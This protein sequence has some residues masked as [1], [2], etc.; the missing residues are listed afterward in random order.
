MKYI[1]FKIKNYKGIRDEKLK[2]DTLPEMKIFTLVGLNESG[3]TSV[4]EA[5]NSFQ[6]GIKN[7]DGII[8]K[9]KKMNFNDT[10]EL[11]A[12]AALD[13]SDEKLIKRFCEEKGFLLQE[14]ISKVTITRKLKY[15]DSKPEGK[16]LVN[17]SWIINLNGHKTTSRKKAVERLYDINK[18]LWEEVTTYVE[19]SIFPRIILYSNFLFEIP[20]KIY[21][22]KKNKDEATTPKH[23]L[24]TDDQYFLL[25]QDILDSLGQDLRVEDHLLNRYLSGESE[26]LD[27]INHV[28]SA[29]SAKVSEEVFQTWGRVSGIDINGR[30]VTF[31]D[32]VKEDAD[33]Y[34]L[35]LK[36]KEGAK[37]YLVQERSL[38]FRWF[39]AFL[40]FTQFRKFR[41][42]DPENTLFL[43]DEPASNLHQTGQQELLTLLDSLTDKSTVIYSTHSHHLISPKWLAG[44]YIVKNEAINPDEKAITD[45]MS[46]RATDIKVDRYFNF[47]AQ[48]PNQSTHFQPI[49]DV[50]EYRPSGLEQI[51]SIAI[52]EGK[53]DYYNF[54]Y[55][56][57][58]N[59]VGLN[60]YPANG[61]GS[62]D[63]IIALYLSWGR[64]FIV[65]LDADSAGH[66]EKNRYLKQFG[67][68][69]DNKIFCLDDVS[70]DFKD[71]TTESL[72]TTE[73]REGVVR[74]IYGSTATYDKT[75]YNSAL[76]K[77]YIDGETFKFSKI[78]LGNFK[79]VTDFIKDKMGK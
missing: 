70:S 28:L 67:A 26:D 31:G 21:L 62:L 45:V 77:L 71:Y 35:E 78:T 42:G 25:I 55:Y 22:A 68:I 49:L 51:P 54:S 57:L 61:A 65:I 14:E 29:M 13:K 19:K 34:Y 1:E 17:S 37:T 60:F 27:N 32:S 46:V 23:L 69:V 64:E 12:V 15:K 39:F 8:P 79:K 7:K 75:L 66:R 47:A 40:L 11:S 4:L 20:P 24:A 18:E 72:T 52:V 36:V 10:V 59:K 33:G 53:F 38:G 44:A 16:G 63:D 41:K 6:N 9:D 58:L 48:H 76:Q 2:L 50:L 73:D 3:K 30:E 43:L 56:S 74:K 5:I